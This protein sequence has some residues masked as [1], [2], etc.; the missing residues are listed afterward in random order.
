MSG[1]EFCA[2]NIQAHLSV[3]NYFHRN[4]VAIYLPYFSRSV[5]NSSVIFL[6]ESSSR[7]SS[8]RHCEQLKYRCAYNCCENSN[9]FE[10]RVARV[11]SRIIGHKHC[12]LHVMARKLKH[13]VSLDDAVT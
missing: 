1:V 4:L 11:Q 3:V 8:L 9:L 5:A 6:P 12:M 7:G 13:I 2:V 10:R